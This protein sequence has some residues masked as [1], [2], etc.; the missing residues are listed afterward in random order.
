[1]PIFDLTATSAKLT[2]SFGEPFIGTTDR[3]RLTLAVKMGWLDRLTLATGED[4]RELVLYL[5]F[6]HANVGER[7]FLDVKGQ[8]PRKGIGVLHYLKGRKGDFDST[9]PTLIF[10]NYVTNQQ[11]DQL[12]AMAMVGRYP[13]SL[14][15]SVADDAGIKY[16]WE[17]DGSGKE[18][19]NQTYPRVAIEAVSFE[20]PVSP[21][22]VEDNGSG[23]ESGKPVAQTEVE[24]LAAL[25]TITRLLQWLLGA[26]IVLGLSLLWR[27]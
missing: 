3:W 20:V 11:M 5:N 1:M 21:P 9:P 22:G 7:S 12:V 27:R 10:E 25:N 14:T 2:N 17:P 26:A 8:E 6:I 19:D 18:W 15:V 13:T 4:P 24:L 23:S 16:G